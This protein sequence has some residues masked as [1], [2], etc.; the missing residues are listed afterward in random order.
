MGAGNNIDG[1]QS[2]T[3]HQQQ[4]TNKGKETLAR[5]DYKFHHRFRVRYSEIDGQGIVFN[6]HYLTYFD[7]AITEYLRSLPFD[8][9][10]E[11]KSSGMDFHT[12]RALVEYAKPIAFD[13]EFDVCVKV[14]RIGRSSIRFDFEVHGRASEDLRS[15]GEIIWVY[16]N[17][18]TH[19]TEVVAARLSELIVTR[20][21]LSVK[22]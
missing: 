21:G 17:Q 10:S 8:Y 5:S 2:F 13:E 19:K 4:T 22:S 7:C 1:E 18:T 9:K 3:A 6:A 11:T 12:V 20:E 14:G 16:T 15:T